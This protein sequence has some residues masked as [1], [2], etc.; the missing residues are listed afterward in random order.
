MADLLTDAKARATTVLGGFS[1]GQ[2]M[3]TVLAAVGLVIGG[4]MFT[5]WASRP[6]YAPLFTN[7]SASDAASITG[8]LTSDKVTYK[9][10]DAGATVEVPVNQVY[11]ER[12]KLAA[13][14]LPGSSQSGYSLLDKQGITTSEFTQQV[15]FQRALE[16]E[17]AKTITVID[18]VNAA[19]VHL[20]I[21]RQDVFA[22]STSQASAAVLLSLTPGTSLSPTQ[23]Q[24]VVHLVASSVEGLTPANVT[25]TDS[26][27]DVLAAPGTNGTQTAAGD[28]QQQ[29]TQ[30]FQSTIGT[31]L[32]DMLA[33]VIGPNHA[34][35]R[36]T[37]DLN[38]DQKASTTETY[39]NNKPI[40]LNQTTT[41]ETYSGQGNPPALGT[42][43]AS[44][45][46]LPAS[47]GGATTYNSQQNATNFAV[48]KVTQQI[49][50]APGT[51]NRMS[52]AVAVDSNTKGV[53]ATT[54]KQLV[55][56]AAGIQP[57]RGDTV[58]VALVPFDTTT[59]AQAQKELKAAAAAK[60][61]TKMFGEI[62]TGV[63]ILLLLLVVGAVLRSAR[64]APQRLPLPI[65]PDLTLEPPSRGLGAGTLVS[66]GH[67]PVRYEPLT[68]SQ[69]ELAAADMSRQ[70]NSARPD[71]VAGLLR[72]W[73]TERSA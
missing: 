61:Q 71:E 58:D 42:L 17:L 62:K 38:Y 3:M 47:T 28:T 32:Q 14:G 4:F 21:P 46:T 73:L 44:P 33:Q 64:R 11:S 15:D 23:V 10:A 22:Q 50:Q 51:V 68:K 57:S 36:V 7:L 35:V 52:I 34:V 25:V 53:D 16:G 67:A 37:A 66:P 13:A 5:S 8:K 27:G 70:L 24:A 19:S 39:P 65:S 9:L 72:D 30:S 63:M 20:V 69:A 48:D 45:T 31:S 1:P 59:A 2:K 6:S 26:K 41:Q 56:A 29:Q 55:S 43:S 60:S 40:P 12:I 18:G 49:V 54:I